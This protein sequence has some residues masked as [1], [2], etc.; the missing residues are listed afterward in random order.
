MAE[1]GFEHTPAS[2]REAVGLFPAETSATGIF[3]PPHPIQMLTEGRSARATLRVADRPHGGR[4]A[5]GAKGTHPRSFKGLDSF[6]TPTSARRASPPRRP[7]TTGV[8]PAR[9]AGCL[10]AGIGGARW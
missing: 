6:F 9:R 2:G 1:P 4:L 7:G 3:K 10:H 8:T 5:A